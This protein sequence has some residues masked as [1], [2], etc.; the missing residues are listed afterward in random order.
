MV[1]EPAES[2]ILINSLLVVA[3]VEDVMNEILSYKR[4]FALFSLQA[5]STCA[6]FISNRSI[7][8][9]NDDPTDAAQDWLFVSLAVVVAA[10]LSCN[11]SSLVV[12]PGPQNFRQD[13]LPWSLVGVSQLLVLFA[14]GQSDGIILH[15]CQQHDNYHREIDHGLG[16]GIHCSLPGDHGHGR[17]HSGLPVFQSGCQHLGLFQIE[18]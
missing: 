15:L 4:F 8:R 6:L 11:P 14:G 16:H 7:G 9:A 3:G 5:F 13:G 17:L 10:V 12:A 1:V 18:P 2:V